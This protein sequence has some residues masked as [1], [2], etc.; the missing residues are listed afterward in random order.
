MEK[1]FFHHSTDDDDDDTWFKFLTRVAIP[2]IAALFWILFAVCVGFIG[3]IGHNMWLHGQLRAYR[4]LT[5]RENQ[6]R[7]GLCTAA[8][9]QRLVRWWQRRCNCC[10]TNSTTEQQEA[11]TGADS[12]DPEA[13]PVAD[14]PSGE[15]QSPPEQSPPPRPNPP[16][17]EEPAE[18]QQ[19]DQTAVMQPTHP[20]PGQK[21]ATAHPGPDQKAATAHPGP[22]PT[23]AMAHPGPDQKAAT[24]HPGPDQ[25]AATAHPGP[26]PTA[27]TAHSGPDQVIQALMPPTMIPYFPLPRNNS[28]RR[29][30]ENADSAVQDSQ[31]IK[32]WISETARMLHHLQLMNAQRRGSWNSLYENTGT[33]SVTGSFEQATG[34]QYRQAPPLPKKPRQSRQSSMGTRAL[35]PPPARTSSLPRREKKSKNRIETLPLHGERDLPLQF[36]GKYQMGPPSENDYYE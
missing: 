26:D 25:K 32:A 20:G 30:K 31:D 18:A 35:P 15:Q 27:A 10:K 21:A 1:L 17:Q 28:F 34:W 33:E 5:A 36:I 7:T 4:L 12:A 9:H 24:A 14:Q 13:P 11:P 22:D 8:F 2:V 3:L 16:R 29:K 6:A 23:A 19:L